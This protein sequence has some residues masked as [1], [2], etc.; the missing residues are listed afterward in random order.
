[1]GAFRNAGALDPVLAGVLA[2]VL[3]TW[4]TFLPSFL[5]IFTGAPYIEYLRGNKNLTAALSG[6]TAAVVGVVLNLGVWF[7]IHTLFA[8]VTE[9]EIGPFHLLHPTWDLIDWGALG[10][11]LVAFFLYI[12]LKWDM[13]K[14]IGACAVLG[15]L[16]VFMT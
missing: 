12:K 3:V 5:F 13:L 6:I 2:S 15:L 10:I 8:E 9:V 16:V 7:S 11:T 1:M 4:V 14:V